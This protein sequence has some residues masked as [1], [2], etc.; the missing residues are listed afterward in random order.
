MWRVCEFGEATGSEGGTIIRDEEH[1]HGARITL[2]SATPSAPFTIT[3]GI[4]GWMVHTRFFGNEF[5]AAADY[6]AMKQGLEDIL[7]V[8]PAESE[9]SS[10]DGTGTVVA[11]IN[12]FLQRFP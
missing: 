8:I 7:A 6:E 5:E 9:A 2:E 1:V 11:A 4:Y 12:F 3:C 10:R